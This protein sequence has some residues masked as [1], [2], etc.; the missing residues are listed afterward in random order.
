MSEK[1]EEPELTYADSEA[2]Q[3]VERAVHQMWE[4]IGELSRIHPKRRERFRV[5]IFGSARIQPGAPIY[6]DVKHLATELSQ[7]GC[8]IVTGG[9]PGLMQA[10]NEGAQIGD[11]ENKTQSCGIR[12]ELPFEQ[13]ANPFVEQVTAHRTFFSRLAHFMQVSDAFVVVP[14]GIG[15]T[16]ETMLVWQLLQVRH[17]E[18]VPL[19]FVGKMWAELVEWGKRHMV[20]VEHPLASARDMDIPR[21]VNNAGEAVEL[22]KPHIQ[23]RAAEHRE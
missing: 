12:I 3:V 20:D 17:V 22:L 19:I 11:P 10:A 4:V 6:E 7:L 2:L 15:T 16:L 8:D 18:N 13:G 14:G 9:G 1:P 23:G 5:A 21:C